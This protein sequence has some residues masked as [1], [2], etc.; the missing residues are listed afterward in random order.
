MTNRRIGRQTDKPREPKWTTSLPD[1][2]KRIVAKESMLPCE[3]LFPASAQT[4]LRYFDQLIMTD[5]V[6]QP[7]VGEACLPWMRDWAAVFFGSYD[8]EKGKRLIWEYFLMVAKKNGKSTIAAGV[9]LAVLLMNWRKSAP[10]LILSPSKKASDNVFIAARDMVKADPE[11]MDLLHIKENERK[12][13]HRTT[14]ATLEVV[15]AEG[16]TVAGTKAAGVLIDELWEFG[17]ISGA[18]GMIDE[19]TG[20]LT[21]RPEGFIIYLTTQSEREP[22]GVFKDKL[23]YARKIRNGQINRK[24]FL[25]VIYEFPRAMID[26]EKHLES[27]NWYIPNPNWGA[28]VR[29]DYL[30]QKFDE[31]REAGDGPLGVWM[32]KHLNVQ[33]GLYYESG[34]WQGAPYWLQQS[35][36]SLT[37]EN[38]IARSEFLVCGIDQGG[39]DDFLSLAVIGQESGSR[40]YLHWQKS[41]AWRNILEIRKEEAPRCLDFE[42][43]GDLVLT[44]KADE[45]EDLLV[46][47][48]KIL[49]GTGKLFCVGYDKAG[50]RRIIS[51]LVDAL[52]SEE[53][54]V[55]IPQG[56]MMTGDILATERAL[57]ARKFWHG[58]K[59]IMA[60]AV[61]NAAAKQ[62]G[63]SVMITKQSSGGRKIDPLIAL[64]I[65]MGAILRNPAPPKKSWWDS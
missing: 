26:A 18:S 22:A 60:W 57:A 58:G 50:A 43:D 51:L 12:I 30:L 4:G 53:A 35:D 40:N 15:A 6:G 62:T 33:V 14:N 2:E 9:M 41:W 28:S 20:G 34:G 59:A 63:N 61:G 10:F 48:V 24:T 52:I 64:L 45:G 39:N 16:G 29:E 56:Y 3:P 19:A 11:L 5:V 13:V 47:I 55:P 49:W 54:L 46:E 36:P 42:E 37:L 1:W 17:T 27:A 38:L 65:A 7:T 8:P 23:D 31:K 21:A 44:E 32:A 25:P